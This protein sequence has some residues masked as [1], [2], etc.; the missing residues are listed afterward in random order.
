[1]DSL[2]ER[3]LEYQATGRGYESLVRSIA[4]TV[5]HYPERRYGFTEDDRG[6]FLLFFY[7]RISAIIRRFRPCGKPFEAYLHTNLRWQARTYA[8]RKLALERQ[9]RLTARNDLWIDTFNPSVAA[10]SVPEMDTRRPANTR[11]RIDPNGRFADRGIRRRA[12]L[13]ALKASPYLTLPQIDQVAQLTNCSP[14]ALEEKCLIL[15]ERAERRMRRY[16][17]LSTRRNKAFFRLQC[18]EEEEHA[19]PTDERRRAIHAEC[20]RIRRRYQRARI[21]ARA[22]MRTPTHREIADVLGIPKGSVDSG[23]FYA[24]SA[25]TAGICEKTSQESSVPVL[26]HPE[27]GLSSGYEERTRTCNRKRSQEA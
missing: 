15:R 13:V 6:E 4:L 21:E 2:T 17:I 16:D 11:M 7:P 12:L 5:Y 18:L 22:V 14:Q 3:V 23:I 10:E 1:M 19:S 24:R 27:A 20:Q 26:T 8:S 9:T 25:V